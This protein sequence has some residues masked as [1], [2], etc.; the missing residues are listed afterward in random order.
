MFVNILNGK[1]TKQY[2]WTH[3]SVLFNICYVLQKLLFL[4]ACQCHRSYRRLN[5]VFQLK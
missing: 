4:E 1:V 5:H 2:S 3:S